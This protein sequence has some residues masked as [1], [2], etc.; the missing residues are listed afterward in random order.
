M[1]VCIPKSKIRPGPSVPGLSQWTVPKGG[2]VYDRKEVVYIVNRN[3][4]ATDLQ[5]FISKEEDSALLGV[6]DPHNQK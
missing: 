1:T 3:E 4:D 2:S 5:A 6:V